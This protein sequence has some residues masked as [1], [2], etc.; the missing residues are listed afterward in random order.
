[1]CVV[2]VCVVCVCVWMCVEVDA[3]VDRSVVVEPYIFSSQLVHYKT[4]LSPT[5]GHV[6]LN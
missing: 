6:F 1:M 4:A 3:Q 5:S 2:C